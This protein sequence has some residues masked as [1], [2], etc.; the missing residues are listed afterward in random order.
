MKSSTPRA[1]FGTR[2]FSLIEL[3]VAMSILVVLIV[4][5]MGM[6]DG[7]TKLWKINENRVDS[8][9][10]ARAAINL[11]AA[12]INSMIVS[13]NRAFFSLDRAE[14]LPSTALPVGEANNIFFLTAQA[15]AAQDT[16]SKPTASKPANA[17]DACVVGYF[18]GY[19]K[20]TSGSPENSRN[21]YR[22]FLSSGETHKNIK[23]GVLLSDTLTTT[24]S[25]S[26]PTG[27]EV[28]ARNVTDFKLHAYTVD[29]T[30]QSPTGVVRKFV[31]TNE[32]PIPDFIDIELTALNNEAAKR[33]RQDSDWEDKNSATYKN[34]VRTFKTRVYLRAATVT[35]TT[36]TPAPTPSPTPF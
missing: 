13:T 29:Y 19:D 28:L 18:L 7:A 4:I 11:M 26:S 30:P 25:S 6:V 10:E 33:F 24:P 21:I 1:R 5:L 20:I 35:K 22:Y 27:S 14:K 16:N 15:K 8:Y 34:N 31:Q 36:P 3:M 32:T 12:D 2:A 23:A 9:R 17:S